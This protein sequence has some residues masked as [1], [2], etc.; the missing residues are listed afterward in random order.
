[1]LLGYRN[2]RHLVIV[3]VIGPGPRA[4]H[5]RA[6]FRPDAEYQQSEIDRL[7]GIDPTRHSYLGDWHTH[8]D[9]LPLLSP[10]DK[11]TLKAIAKTPEAQVSS[12]VMLLLSGGQRAWDLRVFEFRTLRAPLQIARELKVYEKPPGHSE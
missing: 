4:H 9:G 12:P 6:G 1:M 7:H 3:A 10:R 2:R 11:K 5:D 8:P